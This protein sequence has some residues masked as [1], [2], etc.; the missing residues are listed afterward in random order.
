MDGDNAF[1]DKISEVHKYRYTGYLNLYDGKK[2]NFCVTDNHNFVVKHRRRVGYMGK[3]EC[4]DWSIE[5]YNDLPRDFII[6]RTNK[7]I[8]KKR[9]KITFSSYREQPHGGFIKREWSFDFG[10]WCELVGWFVAEGNVSIRKRKDGNES[11][12]IQIA[13]KSGWKLEQIKTLLIKMGIAGRDATQHGKTNNGVQFSIS[14]VG[15]HLRDV[16][17]HGASNK[18]VPEYIKNSESQY[19]QRFL[20][21]YA[22]GDGSNRNGSITYSSCSQKLID[23]IQEVLVK[24]GVAGKV[25]CLKCAGTKTQKFGDRNGTRRY[26]IWSCSQLKRQKDSDVSK[27]NIK[28]IFYDDYIY[29]VSVPK[30]IIMVRRNGYPMWSGNSAESAMVYRVGNIVKWIKR[31]RGNDIT[32]TARWLQAEIKENE[33]ERAFIDE[34]GIGA[35]IV[36]ICREAGEPVEGVNVSRPAIQGT[37]FNNQRSELWWTIREQLRTGKLILPSDDFLTG[38]L[39]SPRY[40]HDNLGRTKIE[41]K[42]DIIKRLGRS[43]DSGDALSLTFSGTFLGGDSVDENYVSSLTNESV[44]KVISE[45]QS[46]WAVGTMARRRSS[47]WKS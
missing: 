5:K 20:N 45:I 28:R 21:G 44:A 9:S 30:Q 41:A 4:R 39:I 19:L 22:L 33:I 35:G 12:G 8:G 15:K 27:R 13:Q 16:C 24:L 36:D 43:P 25:T 34:I 2:V 6:R 3:R 46:R 29:C 1:W 47:R 11:I 23:D 18:R 26:D 14:P 17:G 10:D 38:D 32:E 31:V 37:R 42:D 40:L 7:W